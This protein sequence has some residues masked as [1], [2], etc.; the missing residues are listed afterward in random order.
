MFLMT[1]Q[2]QRTA[3]MIV[4]LL[5]V[6]IS[7]FAAVYTRFYNESDWQGINSWNNGLYYLLLE[8][9][10][11]VN[12]VVFLLNDSRHRALYLQNPL[13]KLI[14][15]IKNN[16][17]QSACLVVL[18]YM[19]KQGLWAS[20][21]VVLALFFYN[22]FLDFLFRFFLGRIIYG[23]IT[24]NTKI[25][26]YLILTSKT[27]A[28]SVIRRF[29]A[30]MGRC[31]DIAGIIL[32]DGKGD[33]AEIEGIKVAADLD[34]LVKLSDDYD[35]IIY[36][37]DNSKETEKIRKV[38]NGAEI[39]LIIVPSF[40]GYSLSNEIFEKIGNLNG[41][42]LSFL[43]E[44]KAV[45]G[46]N[47]VVSNIWEAA[48]YIREN[49]DKLRG[50]YI[51]FSNV[52]TTVMAYE[53]DEYRR[54]QNE[55]EIVFPDGAPISKIQRHD[56]CSRARRVAGPDFMRQMFVSSIGGGLSMYFYGSSQKTI[57]EL[58][59]NIEKNYP[60]LDVRGYE[61]PPFRNLTDEEDAEAVRRINESGADI[62]W[63]G[64]GAPKQEKWMNAH[65]DRINA[66]MLGVG[67]GFDFHAGTIKRAPEWMQ[68]VGLEWLFRLFQD[69]KRLIKRYLVTNLK[70][71]YYLTLKKQ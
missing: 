29:R 31:N 25:K 41:F 20:R 11:A 19:I 9:V 13:E 6:I 48:V 43:A 55:A 7:F 10:I 45:L 38:F 40:C 26:K 15:V 70:F 18:L 22:I 65:K 44:R 68:H 27:N 53:D 30:E 21:A 37:D 49:I 32:T 67:A 1:K 39:P 36:I 63:V 56:G 35:E 51:C 23:I 14:N 52:H 4:D 69:P 64:L 47:F 5:A 24:K 58:K 42:K 2:S 3:V 28:S 61:S 60:G 62:V 17:L 33:I 12:I 16:V 59:K 46:V 57:D 54:V 8:L 71:M 66:L 34:S 50:K